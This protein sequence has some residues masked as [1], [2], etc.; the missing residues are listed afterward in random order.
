MK[1]FTLRFAAAFLSLVTCLHAFK[2]DVFVSG[3]E[4]YHT[5][6]IPAI[7]RAADGTLLAFCEGRK[8]S[9]SDT[10]NIDLLLKR[11]TDEGRTWGATIVVWNDG[12]NTCGN[13]SPVLDVT[14][15]YI[16]LLMSHN[17]GSDTQDMISN[18]TSTGTRTVWVT[19][20]NDNGLTWAPATNIT[21]QVKNPS[22]RW[23]ATGPG[24]SI[25]IQNGPHAGRLVVPVCYGNPRS[26]GVFYSD[27]HGQSWITSNDVRGLV[28]ETQVVETFG[29]PGKLLINM[30]SGYDHKCRT[31]STSTN[32]GVTWSSPPSQVIEQTD[33]PCQ[34]S[35]IRWENPA[36]A[37]GGLLLFSNPAS[38][39]DRR[40]K[41]T[42][43]SSADDGATWPRSLVLHEGMAAYSCLIRLDAETAGCLYETGEGTYSSANLYKR[44]TFQ[45]FPLGELGAYAPADLLS[46]RNVTAGSG[47]STSFAAAA[48]GATSFRW[49]VS[50]DGGTNWTNISAL[51]NPSAHY[52]G[53]NSAT[54][55]VTNASGTMNGYLY[56]YVAINSYGETV[57]NSAVLT[58]KTTNLGRAA[59]ITLDNSDNIYV[60]DS[61][62]GAVRKITPAG[63]ISFFSNT[64]AFAMPSGIKINPLTGALHV[65]ET[66]ARAVRTL[67]A[68]G[69]ANVLPGSAAASLGGPTA[70][71]VDKTGNTYI[72]DTAS[73]TV[74]IIT[75]DGNATIIAGAPGIPGS[76]DATGTAARFIQPAGVSVDITTT[77]TSGYLYVA[78]TGNHTIRIIDMGTRKVTTFAGQSGIA[79]YASTI[80][81]LFNAPKGIIV[82][83][84]GVVY[85]ADSG[86]HVI[87]E[88]TSQTD[89]MPAIAGSPEI[90][91]FIDDSGT[92]SRFNRPSDLALGRD[93]SLYVVDHDNN[94]IRKLAFDGRV[95][96]INTV[97]DAGIPGGNGSSGGGG[98]A[99][100]S[101]GGGGAA[102]AWF[103]VALGVLFLLRGSIM[104]KKM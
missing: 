90:A 14:T 52:S 34:A 4:G 35:I 97:L 44:I 10:G 23:Y 78:D 28:G 93:G 60:T 29:A 36:L 74:R 80:P 69:S 71:A 61:G 53:W 18:G 37:T 1:R 102:S 50:T 33:P 7:I 65:I 39:T 75:A 91:G 20:S 77:G 47:G 38:G 51:A 76:T 55:T 56:R 89:P 72:A 12:D 25:Q 62:Y 83:G 67:S 31:Q 87:R 30:R 70:V 3:Q 66:G 81:A 49:Q 98:N 5:Y 59:G 64:N 21:S 15:G 101:S 32:G 99:G 46:P 11:S 104:W 95:S 57:G 84:A 24:I 68:S 16:W 63:I 54:L 41:L 27:D 103:M 43:R 6:R 2:S 92:Y 82:D 88:I 26:S 94:V 40:E 79:G 19:H 8:N 45:T 13:P 9:R 85:V 100:S 48:S 22:W 86:N 17:L 96:T 73:H 42:I 58:V